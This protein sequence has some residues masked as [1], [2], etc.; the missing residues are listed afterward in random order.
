MLL[1]F[2]IVILMVT[3]PGVLLLCWIWKLLFN[4]CYWFYLW[5]QLMQGDP[6]SEFKF[7][8]SLLFDDFKN[9][10][11]WFF[12]DLI[13]DLC[14]LRFHI[15][16]RF[17]AESVKLQSSAVIMELIGMSTHWQQLTKM[18][19]ELLV[20]AFQVCSPS[21]MIYIIHITHTDFEIFW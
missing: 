6:I 3:V 16:H 14:S 5:L 7:L 10:L 18:Y 1:L 8:A 9:I 20:Q 4:N 19:I 17:K 2:F 13:I 11:F 21:F 12:G 15:L